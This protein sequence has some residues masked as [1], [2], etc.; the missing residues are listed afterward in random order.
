MKIKKYLPWWIKI[1]AKIVLARLPIEYG[2]WKKLHFFEHG[3]MDNP[4]YA[5]NVFNSHFERTKFEPGFVSLELGPGDSLLSA[6]VSKS[7]GGSASY[8][9]DAGE[10]AVKNIQP[11]MIMADFLNKQ[12]L[13]VPN[14]K[15]AQSLEEILKICNSNYGVSGLS[16]LKEIPAQSVDFIWSHAVLEHI[17]KEE[18]LDTFIELRRILKNNGVCSH[19]ID[20]KDHLG[21]DLN[22]LRFSEPVWESNFMAKS[23]FYTNRLRYSEMLEVFS[24]AG[25]DVEVVEV[26]RWDKL[27]TP[28]E[29]F[30]R[31]FTEL[32]EE[33]LRISEFS[34]ILRPSHK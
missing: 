27:P 21:G 10:F 22:N 11:Y 19:K 34:V 25:F 12:K 24:K 7:F 4:N 26:K 13:D 20:L 28:R 14:I 29:K 6:I 33:E 18:F 1:A 3:S 30:S 31:K 5:Y 8:L 16:F 2:I 9:V 17:K 23:G 15:L 32:S